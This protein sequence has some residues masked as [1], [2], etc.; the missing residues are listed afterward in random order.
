MDERSFRKMAKGRQETKKVMVFV[1]ATWRGLLDRTITDRGDKTAVPSIT[2]E[3][4][5]I[6]YQFVRMLKLVELLA[7]KAKRARSTTVVFVPLAKASPI[8]V[9]G[10]AGLLRARQKGGTATARW[11]TL[12]LAD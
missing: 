10:A 1:A 9:L 4:N 8:V 2:I 7:A 5:S 3:K 12:T 6:H 11:I